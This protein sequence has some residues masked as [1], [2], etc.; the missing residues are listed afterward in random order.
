MRQL[1]A[2]LLVLTLAVLAG[3]GGNTEP[4]VAE[5]PAAAFGNAV[6][7]EHLDETFLS[8]NPASPESEE[9][10]DPAG[11]VWTIAPFS[12]SESIDLPL[13]LHGDGD[14]GFYV[15]GVQE[16]E[17][18]LHLVY[19]CDSAGNVLQATVLPVHGTMDVSVGDIGVVCRGDTIYFDY[20]EIISPGGGDQPGE[21]NRY[22]AA[23]DMNGMLRFSI[24]VDDL[25]TTE[26][27]DFL[28]IG[29][30]M[31]GDSCI[32][33]TEHQVIALDQNGEISWSAET[34]RTLYQMCDGQDGIIYFLTAFDGNDLLCLDAETHSI[35]GPLCSLDDTMYSL[36]PGILDYDILLKDNNAGSQYLY[37]WSRD[38]GEITL[39][40]DLGA[41]G[42]LDLGTIVTT[43]AGVP[44]FD[45]VGLMGVKALGQL[46]Q[47]PVASDTVSLT[48]G[49]CGG[50]SMTADLAVSQ[51]NSQHTD[52]YLT[53]REYDSP[54]DLNL[55]IVAGT[56]PD[57]VCFAGLCQE[58]YL[59]NGCFLDLYELMGEDQKEQLLPKY[60]Q[61]FETDGGLYHISPVFG[62]EL[63]LG[64]RTWLDI[65]PGSYQDMLDAAEQLPDDW[66]ALSMS[67]EWALKTML[68]RGLC[69]FVDFDSRTCDFENAEFE[70]LLGLSSLG[71]EMNE[72]N[73]LRYQ[74]TLFEFHS[75]CSDSIEE[76]DLETSCFLLGFPENGALYT[77]PGDTFGICSGSEHSDLAWEFLSLLL[78]K[79]MQQA[80][81]G[82]T[83]LFPILQ[84]VYEEMAPEDMKDLIEAASGRCVSN[85]PIFD[86]V[87]DEAQGY[88][89]GNQ[90]AAQTARYIQSRV[91][92]YLGEQN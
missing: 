75:C 85:S 5:E 42:V 10:L 19:H 56:G 4:P 6:L 78:T 86:I 59:R 46:V 89:A 54:E 2:L 43:A 36:R 65:A 26:Y 52:A 63:L 77:E 64:D 91:S 87:W 20:T 61:T 47:E 24:P 3:C 40:L 11:Y 13:V 21:Y 37:G 60:R 71:V 39:L 7:P 45:Y 92:I 29:L 23:C 44:V 62:C 28:V 70:A 1:T 12:C 82:V 69:G 90:S 16:Q 88:F 27:D 9:R 57:L 50:L 55:E 72:E 48:L 81:A 15:H 79:D 17:D 84:S 76:S 67:P 74:G 18:M 35:S 83:S 25:N 22:I 34:D 14:G 66:S 41:L 53:V 30:S 31:L 58:D 51:F 8:E 68:I 80:Y 49:V 73:L 38:T 32:V 33:A